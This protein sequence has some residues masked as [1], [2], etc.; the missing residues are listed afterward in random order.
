MINS[1]ENSVVFMLPNQKWGKV[2]HKILDSAE[3]L[4]EPDDKSFPL[5]ALENIEVKG[6]SMVL[7]RLDKP[8]QND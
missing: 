4:F 5:N 8:V 3:N 7:L 1:D 6:I 2:W